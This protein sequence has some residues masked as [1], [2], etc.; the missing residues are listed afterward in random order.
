M[1]Q[2][3]TSPIHRFVRHLAVAAAC[4]VMAAATLPAHASRYAAIVIDANSGKT[5][6]SADADSPRYPA[7]LTKMMTLYMVFEAMKS[8]R[9]GKDTRVSFSAQA[10]AKPPT[11]LGVKPGGSVT[12]EA[13]ILALVTKSAN[14]AAAALGEMIGGSE[15]NFARMM[16]A[17]A[18][19]LG[20]GSTTF[21]N[22]S[23]LPD[24]AQRTT[25]R[26]MAILGI[27]LREHFPQYYGYFSTRSFTFGKAR[28]ANHNKLL[29][30]VNGVDGIKTGYIRASGFNLVTSVKTGGRSIVAVVMGGQSGPSRDAHMVDLIAQHLPKASR[31]DGAPLVALAAP[32]PGPKVVA[33][34][35]DQAPKAAAAMALPKIDIPTPDARPARVEEAVASAAPAAVEVVAAQPPAPAAEETGEGDIDTIST[36]STGARG[37]VVQIAS[38]PSKQEAIGALERASAR[39]GAIL[40]GAEAFTVPFEKGG[41]V[42]HR[43]RFGGFATKT[44]AWSTCAALKKKRIECYAAEQ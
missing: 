28:M 8:G 15:D 12:V 38:S 23:G 10:S 3:S 17:R 39:A 36:G 1:R 40:S 21:R 42:Y 25:A 24:D 31:R 18:R 27:A 2:A 33:A 11:K 26:D 37:W 22:A 13:A 41:T 44:A 19:R 29:G 16:T 34:A 9:I 35:P 30:R 20:M 4:V 7:S 6:F 43:A 14:D 5:L 32:E